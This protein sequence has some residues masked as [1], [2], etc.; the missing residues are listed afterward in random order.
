VADAAGRHQT[1]SSL[2]AAGWQVLERTIVDVLA[3]SGPT[4]PDDV[5][6]VVAVGGHPFDLA[7]VAEVVRDG[8][9][10]LPLVVIGPHLDR[11]LF[12]RLLRVGGAIAYGMAG[13]DVVELVEL[14]TR[15]R[16]CASSPGLAA[17]LLRDMG[18]HAD[19]RDLELVGLL[20]AG[21]QRADLVAEVARRPELFA[22]V[23]DDAV[24]RSLK[25][26]ALAAGPRDRVWLAQVLDH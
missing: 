4:W 25:R 6:V 26:L 10:A 24:E 1:A 11:D 21:H 5:A 22:A 2:S 9:R 17:A 7:A 18:T 15:A 16:G 23:V 3:T 13:D 14:A 20:L 19:T 12:E 8:H